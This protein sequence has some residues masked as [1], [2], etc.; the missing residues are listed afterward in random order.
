MEKVLC[1]HP[2]SIIDKDASFSFNC[3]SEVLKENA[4]TVAAATADN[5]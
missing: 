1:S 4:V 3:S 2:E 5:C